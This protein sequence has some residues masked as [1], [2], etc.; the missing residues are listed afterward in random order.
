MGSVERRKSECF[1]DFAGDKI[2]RAFSRGSIQEEAKTKID[3]SVFCSSEGNERHTRRSSVCGC[4]CKKY[5]FS[6]VH[7]R[8]T[9]TKDAKRGLRLLH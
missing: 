7:V 1:G 9:V 4:F 8:P 5:R 2:K 3:K 6:D